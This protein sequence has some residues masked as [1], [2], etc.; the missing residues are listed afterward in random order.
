MR[1]KNCVLAEALDS[2]VCGCGGQAAP[3][4]AG[5]LVEIGLRLHSECP[6]ADPAFIQRLG[7]TLSD[8]H[9]RLGCPSWRAP[10][11]WPRLLRVGAAAAMAGALLLVLTVRVP[12]LQRPV[13]AGLS[14]VI[15]VFRQA[16]VEQT[17]QQT[18]SPPTVQV[19]TYA[20]LEE[21]RAA[22]GFPIRV[23]SYLPKGLVLDD[24]SVVDAA[25]G[26]RVM[27]R[28]T[29]GLAELSHRRGSVLI[30]EFQSSESPEAQPLVLEVGPESIER[31]QVAGKP[32][33]WIQGRWMPGG[34]WVRGGQEGALM[35]QDGDVL[36][37]VIG[38]LTQAESV[39]IIE[40]MLQ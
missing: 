12:G 11:L 40:S 24:V 2:L 6:E 26:R 20:R 15:T 38:S 9:A 19:E 7:R 36:I 10:E 31:L 1:E 23:P 18:T 39:R 37:Q 22:A 16:R 27:L 14:R 3:E 30:Q 35:V 17:S 13:Q 32:A 28:Y 34:R 33:L 8:E 25:E 21:A 5:P 4:E 29:D